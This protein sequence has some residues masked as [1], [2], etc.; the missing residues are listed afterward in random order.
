[1]PELS[2][3]VVCSYGVSHQQE[4]ML[5]LFSLY[6]NMMGDLQNFNEF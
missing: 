1:M 5:N 6:L 4:F 3:V 2:K